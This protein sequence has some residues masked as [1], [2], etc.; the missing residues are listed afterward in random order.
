MLALGALLLGSCDFKWP[1]SMEEQQALRPLTAPRPAPEG[2]VPVG[3]VEIID[4]RE[5]VSDLEN[6]YV[7]DSGVATMGRRLFPTHCAICHGPDGRGGG[8]IS[9]K[10]PPAPDLRY[11]TICRRTDGFIYGTITAGGKAMPKMRDGLTS[12]ER[13]A[14][15]AHVRRLQ[16]EGCVA[17]VPTLPDGTPLPGATP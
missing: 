7:H 4:D 2:S 9:K 8:K 13:W 10:F 6:P 1:A 12:R 17:A 5:D 15:V 16:Q 14:L 3:G 11:Q